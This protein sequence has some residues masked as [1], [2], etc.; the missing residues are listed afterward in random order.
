MSLTKPCEA[1]RKQQP[2]KVFIHA[3]KDHQLFEGKE[4]CFSGP[5]PVSNVKKVE[6]KGERVERRAS[7]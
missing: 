1:R 4:N 7:E 3:L 2:A 5:L 6:R